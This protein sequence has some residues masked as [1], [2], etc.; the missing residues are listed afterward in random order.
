MQNASRIGVLCT[1][2]LSMLGFL[3]LKVIIL[4]HLQQS[5]MAATGDPL[6]VTSDAMFWV[7]LALCLLPIMGVSALLFWLA[8]EHMDDERLSLT[9][10]LLLRDGSPVLGTV[11]GQRR[12]ELEID[13]I[14]PEGVRRQLIV[15]AYH[16]SDLERHPAGSE[17]TLLLDPQAPTDCVAPAL[18]GA[19][20]AASEAIEDRRPDDRVGLALPDDAPT[21][22]PAVSF[23]LTSTLHPVRSPLALV[24]R[25]LMAF[26]RRKP[27]EIGALSLV[28]GHLVQTLNEGGARRA[29]DLNEPF[30]ADLSVWVLSNQEA[31]VH[32]ALRQR[33]A[34]PSEPSLILQTEL[35]QELLGADLPIL[36]SSGPY[37]DPAAFLGLWEQVRY[38]AKGH[39]EEVA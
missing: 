36:Q 27:L 31:A 7:V 28:D 34:P 19:E 32:V 9:E 29:V 35:P 39:G 4:I 38:H 16:L 1:A 22:G 25:R 14:D 30:A 6:A 33:G 8:S 11:S 10:K 37:L 23:P 26:R 17:V 13:Y 21:L 15:E 3:F 24:I 20:F 5:A 12:H 18:L 2:F